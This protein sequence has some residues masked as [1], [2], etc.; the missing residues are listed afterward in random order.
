MSKLYRTCRIHFFLYACLKL[1]FMI[2]ICLHQ[3]GAMKRDSLNASKKL[4]RRG[5]NHCMDEHPSL[6][7]NHTLSNFKCC[8]IGFL[9][10]G[11]KF[12]NMN[13]CKCFIIRPTDSIKQNFSIVEKISEKR[14][15]LISTL[16]NL[17]A[18]PVNCTLI[19]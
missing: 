9:I 5:K 2:N 4:E 11:E 10:F 18:F 6:Y 12:W 17:I 16:L 13:L 3:V 15:L 1:E 7:D 19:L 8:Q 14:Y